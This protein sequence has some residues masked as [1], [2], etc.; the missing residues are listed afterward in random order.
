MS[1]S[2]SPTQ[3]NG[4]AQASVA[5]ENMS[6]SEPVKVASCSHRCDATHDHQVMS[7]ISED[8]LVLAN[9]AVADSDQ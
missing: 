5:V 3:V 2:S 7:M 4:R 8:R 1:L 6:G 9:S